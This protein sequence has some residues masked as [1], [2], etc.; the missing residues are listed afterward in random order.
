MLAVH[1]TPVNNTK[2]ILK[3]GIRKT[4]KGVYCFPLTGHKTMD[5]WWVNF[6]NQAGARNRKQYNGIVFRIS[7]KDL[8]AYFGHWIGATTKCDFKKEITDLKELGS[9]FREAMLWRM[10][11]E[12]ARAHNLDHGIYEYD[13]LHSMYLNLA[14]TELANNSKALADKLNSLDFISKVLDD[15]QIVLSNSI[16]ANRIIKVIPQGNEFGRV[17][18]Q[19]KKNNSTAR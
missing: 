19:Q 12:V 14:E 10:G 3:N 5:K 16:P 1:W 17:L 13:T 7:K 9:Q 11:E 6:F 2:A 18:R 4:K 8:P 15:Y